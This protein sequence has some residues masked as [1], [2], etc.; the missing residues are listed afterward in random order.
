M[1]RIAREIMK[2]K[3]SIHDGSAVNSSM[4]SCPTRSF[5]SLKDDTSGKLNIKFFAVLF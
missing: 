2:P 3:A 4:D 1:E 5:A